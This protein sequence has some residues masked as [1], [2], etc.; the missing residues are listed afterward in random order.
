MADPFQEFVQFHSHVSQLK[1]IN[2]QDRGNY[3]SKVSAVL[4]TTEIGRQVLHCF[5][6]Q[7]PEISRS[8]VFNTENDPIFEMGKFDVAF[9]LRPY[10]HGEEGY[11]KT[12]YLSLEVHPVVALFDIVHEMNHSCHT[13][14]LKKDYLAINEVLDQGVNENDGSEKK[15]LALLNLEAIHSAGE[16]VESF[17]TE[18]QFFMEMLAVLPENYLDLPYKTD[19][20]FE[21]SLTL[22]AYY[23]KLV[24]LAKNHRLAYF[25]VSMYVK[26][27]VFTKESVFEESKDPFFQQESPRLVH[28]LIRKGRDLNYEFRKRPSFRYSDIWWSSFYPIMAS[29][30]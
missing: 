8:V 18:I 26:A 7:D 19:L 2:K 25:V 30:E 29:T 3:L 15:L 12:L 13:K 27:K 9:M 6:Q 5:F 4:S 10:E 24:S 17:W 22:R 1:N 23:M 14:R 16:E 21:E 11:E 28:A 20:F